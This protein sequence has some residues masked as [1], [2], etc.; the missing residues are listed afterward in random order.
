MRRFDMGYVRGYFLEKRLEHGERTCNLPA[1]CF[2]GA[3]L[4][5][6]NNGVCAGRECQTH[7]YR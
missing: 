7:E 5:A 6:Y 1:A 2:G 4:A 3:V